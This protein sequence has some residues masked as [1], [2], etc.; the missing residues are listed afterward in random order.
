M[1]WTTGPEAAMWN[2]HPEGEEPVDHPQ[3]YGTFRGEK[4]PCVENVVEVQHQVKDRLQ[5][6][7]IY[8]NETQSYLYQ[9][10]GPKGLQS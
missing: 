8:H 3:T 5:C 4:M 7:L 9:T 2:S 10:L 1:T 6:R